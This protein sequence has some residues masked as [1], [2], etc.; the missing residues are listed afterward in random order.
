MV[1]NNDNEYDQS[2]QT[3]P[4]ATSRP[5]S[6]GRRRTERPIETAG[7]APEA[8]RRR[9][10]RA[11]TL[12]ITAASRT[13][14]SGSRREWSEARC[15]GKNGRS[16]TTDESGTADRRASQSNWSGLSLP[17]QPERWPGQT[18]AAAHGGISDNRNLDSDFDALG[19]DSLLPSTASLV[20]PPPT[21][22]T[23]VEPRTFSRRRG[24]ADAREGRIFRAYCIRT[25]SRSQNRAQ[26]SGSFGCGRSDRALARQ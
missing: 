13:V 21:T 1:T 15:L 17:F 16:L 26:I 10:V 20:K 4:S 25:T 14:R 7:I 9:M 24:E 5:R 11:D 22:G 3:P 6:R 2:L 23:S 12:R 19:P 18:P 8:I